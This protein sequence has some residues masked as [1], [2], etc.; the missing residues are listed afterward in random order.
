MENPFLAGGVG[1][2]VLPPQIISE[3]KASHR[4]IALSE[5]AASRG[6]AYPRTHTARRRLPKKS[7]PLW[8]LRLARAVVHTH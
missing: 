2:Y 8:R 3:R 4:K 7:R 1:H 5:I 6:T